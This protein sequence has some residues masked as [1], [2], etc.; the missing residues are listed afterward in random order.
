MY[1]ICL[2]PA[3][4]PID[5]RDKMGADLNGDSLRI[6]DQSRLWLGLRLRLRIYGTNMLE[7][8]TKCGSIT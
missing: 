8:V 7:K 5:G 4:D 1:N 2:L 3:S 6:S